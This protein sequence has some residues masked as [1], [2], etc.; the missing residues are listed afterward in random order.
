M[1]IRYSEKAKSFI[2]S[3][4]VNTD[5]K[6]IINVIMGESMQAVRNVAKNTALK[7]LKRGHTLTINSGAPNEINVWR[8][9]EWDNTPEVFK[10]GL[11]GSKYLIKKQMTSAKKG[12]FIETTISSRLNPKY[13][14]GER[15]AGNVD[16]KQDLITKWSRSKIIDL[17]EFVRLYH[18]SLFKFNIDAKVIKLA[19]N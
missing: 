13:E 17:E 11:I 15:V 4:T 6:E 18:L 16:E 19:Q 3:I 14:L 7:A 8:E 2:G 12:R 10:Y 5:K 9:E 1:Y